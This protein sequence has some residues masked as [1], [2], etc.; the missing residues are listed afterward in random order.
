M[1]YKQ[2]NKLSASWFF[3]TIYD[4]VLV[5]LTDARSSFDVWSTVVK[6]F[7]S[8]STLTISTLRHSLYSKKK[9]QLTIKEYLAKIKNLCDTLVAAG[10]VLSEQE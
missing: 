2:Q 5:H 9:G 4:D 10:S 7:A 8:K 3:S 6:R 1:F